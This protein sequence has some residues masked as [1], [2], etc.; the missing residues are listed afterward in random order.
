MGVEIVD[1]NLLDIHPP[2]AVVPAYRDVADAME[3][4]EQRINEAQGYYASR[5][6]SAVGEAAVRTLGDTADDAGP[7]TLTD[8]ARSRRGVDVVSAAFRLAADRRHMETGRTVRTA[9]P[10]LSGEASAVSERGPPGPD[11]ARRTA[12]ER[13]AVPEPARPA[14]RTARVDRPAPLLEDDGRDLVRPAA[15][16]HRSRVPGRQHLLMMKPG[17][18][19][20]P[21]TV[22]PLGPAT[23]PGGPPEIQPPRQRPRARSIETS[24]HPQ[25]SQ[26]PQIQTQ[27][28]KEK[29][30]MVMFN[31]HPVLVGICVICEICG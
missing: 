20:L 4:R 30:R 11:G 12:A 19:A 10:I 27:D 31:L 5:L 13:R 15:D 1:L 28:K 18:A 6:L 17:D 8:R 26:I 22:A 7:A 29:T 14:P 16:D 24:D 21:A 2:T 9:P 23:G 25:M 3:D